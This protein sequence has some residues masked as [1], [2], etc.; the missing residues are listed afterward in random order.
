ML[1]SVK[2]EAE[3]FLDRDKLSRQVIKRNSPLF[4]SDR[5]NATIRSIEAAQKSW[6]ALYDKYADGKLEREFFLNEKKQYDADMEKMEEELVALRQAQEEEETEQQGSERK[7][8]QAMAFLEEE[9][10]TEDMKEKLIEKV[11]VYP[12]DRIE[13]A[14]KFEGRLNN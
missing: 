7:A 6:I 10:L 8:D 3:I 13:I 11:I 12:G 14:W 1:A 2:R 4:V 5:I 9:E